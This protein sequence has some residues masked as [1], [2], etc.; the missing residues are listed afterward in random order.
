MIS[1]LAAFFSILNVG[2]EIPVGFEKENWISVQKNTLLIKNQIIP[3]NRHRRKGVVELQ[4]FSKATSDGV[5]SMD[6]N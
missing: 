1:T 4:N 6:I 3:R 5:M 2:I